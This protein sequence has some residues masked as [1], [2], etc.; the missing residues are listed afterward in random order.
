MA[1]EL[2]WTGTFEEKTFPALLL[3]IRDSGKTGVLLAKEGEI[4]KRI[5]FQNG[6]P[7]ASRSNVRKDLLG[8]ILCR[9]DRIS[10]AQL[11]ETILE[12]KKNRDDNFGQILIQK[13]FLTPKDLYSECKY[14]FVSI[15]FTLFPWREGTYAFQEQE[16]S[17]LIPKDLPRFRVKFTKLFSEGIRL[18]KDENFIDGILGNTDVNI[19][20]TGL[21]IPPEDL[22]FRGDEL[23]VLDALST[24]RSIEK[25]PAALT[26]D[27][28]LV[29][30]ILYTLSSLGVVEIQSPVSGE[31]KET[32]KLMEGEELPAVSEESLSALMDDLMPEKGS[33]KT[34]ALA[35]ETPDSSEEE[36]IAN[37][38]QSYEFLPPQTET[39]E[40]LEDISEKIQFAVDEAKDTLEEEAPDKTAQEEE[41][42]VGMEDIEEPEDEEGGPEWVEEEVAA[43]IE[44]NEDPSLPLE[45][46]EILE[47]TVKKEAEEAA[48]VPEKKPK[49]KTPQ[50]KKR[51]F[52][53]LASVIM[54]AI[55]IFGGM[56]L[57]YFMKARE[58]KTIVV[59]ETEKEEFVTEMVE[60]KKPSEITQELIEED[61]PAEG[62]ESKP[63]G[64]EKKSE[65][66]DPEEHAVPE[67][68]PPAADKETAEAES[69]AAV[70][71]PSLPVEEK[72]LTE[73]VSPPPQ[74]EPA[75]QKTAP[76][77]NGLYAKGLADF[78]EGN[79]KSA[80]KEWSE[81]IRSAPGSAYSIQVE[82]TS[83]LDYAAKDIKEA[84]PEEKVFVVQTI[85][86]E[87]PAYKVLCGIY[88]NLPEARMALKKLSPYLK[89]QKPMVARLDRLKAK[90][91]D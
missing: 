20:L 80:F 89:A 84:S 57:F 65:T 52:L 25:L 33:K 30:K 73:K 31:E 5:F 28:F 85:F 38:G 1:E 55:L 74:E 70:Q 4:D 87:K 63:A 27:P 72:V 21:D 41:T 83:N 23:P 75:P 76:P 35:E 9:R 2:A 56:A 32:T 90:L 11:D 51:P 48:A 6:E 54:G 50:K 3:E 60:V 44:T 34:A 17:T 49:A 36:V 81:V 53:L 18:I 13:G 7:V 67:E 22:S 45:Q 91:T 61:I 19:N 8:E 42:V 86:D 88:D 64:E 10:R 26:L 39:E 82:I 77:W 16:A 14:Q 47:Q 24:S 59:A 78:Q 46:E 71:K 40:D 29:K 12:S 15:L 79:L 68:A 58:S 69:V 43:Q 66:S 62:E 37:E